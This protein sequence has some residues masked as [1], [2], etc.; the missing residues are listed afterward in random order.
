MYTLFFFIKGTCK[1]IILP[2]DVIQVA[3]AKKKHHPKLMARPLISSSHLGQKEA[4]ANRTYQR[5]YFWR[6]SGLN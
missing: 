4:K 3:L 5:Y 2:V 6:R 1:G